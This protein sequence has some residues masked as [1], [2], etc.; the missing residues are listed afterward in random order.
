MIWLTTAAFAMPMGEEAEFTFEPPGALVPES[1]A[2]REDETLY[3]PGMRFPLEQAPAFLNSQVYSPGGFQGPPGRECDDVNYQYPWRDNFCE[4]RRF[5]MPLC[6]AGTGHQ[7]QDIRPGTC[8]R[9]KHWA[10]ATVT[11]TIVRIGSFSVTLIAED[12]TQHRYLHLEPA[13]LV[14][15]AGDRVV[16]GDRIGRVSNT[17]FDGDGNR[18]PTTTHLHYDIQQN[19]DGRNVFVPPYATLVASYQALLRSPASRC[20]PVPPEGREI[21]D[22]EGCVEYF[23]QERFWRRER[24]EGALGEFL[25]WTNAHSGSAPSNFARTNLTIEQANRY[26]V[27]VHVVAP[28]NRSAAVPYVIRHQGEET[29]VVL[30]QQGE[31]GW[32]DLGT[33]AFAEGGDQ[34][35]EVRDNSGESSP[36]LHISADGVR[37]IRAN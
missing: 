22:T 17:F 21:A 37:L 9:D 20:D 28:R 4:S 11:G 13:S 34:W 15:A 25:T 10:V 7:G 33:F 32:R 14:V 24:T 12:G 36:N 2:G 8:E 19:L 29:T 26:Q 30:D 3:V 1:G 23:G 35:V 18:V 31:T 6:P 27:E 5:R 16:R